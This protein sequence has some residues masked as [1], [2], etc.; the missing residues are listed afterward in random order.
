MIL[1]Q[2]SQLLAQLKEQKLSCVYLFYGREQYLK[3]L[4]SRRIMEAAVGESFPQLNL[5]RFDGN[6]LDM[7]QVCNAVEA[8]PFMAERRCVLISPFPYGSL[9]SRDK[10]LLDG[11]LSA[12]VPST[13]LIL[14]VNDEAFEPKKNAKAKKLIAQVD[15]VGVVLELSG[16]SPEDLQKFLQRRAK[17]LGCNLSKELAQLLLERC[18]NDLLTLTNELEKLCAYAGGGDI[19]KEQLEAVTIKAVRARIYDLAK[20]ILAQQS[21]QAYNTLEELLYLRY[22]P[23]VILS[24][25]WGAYLDLYIAKCAL[26]DGKGQK[27]IAAA[28]EYQGRDFVIRNSLRDCRKLPIGLLRR[29]MMLLADMDLKLKSSRADSS[30]LL[31]QTVAQLLLLGQR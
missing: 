25:L 20:A 8:L 22:Q 31:E 29:S 28:F 9:S 21:R 27:E 13:V 1:E 24:A 18:E 7:E 30:I 4:Y 26:E 2:E 6:K 11:L 19:T 23:T 5:H 3:E 14:M 17:E 15:K 16:R 10:E 12:P